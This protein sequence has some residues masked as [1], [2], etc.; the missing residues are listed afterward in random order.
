[1]ETFMKKLIGLI[2]PLLL[3]GIAIVGDAYAELD[4]S[5]PGPHYEVSLLPVTEYTLQNSSISPSIEE[6]NNIEEEEVDRVSSRLQLALARICVSEA[7]FQVRTND[8]LLIYHVLRNRSRSRQVTIGIMRAYSPQSFNL[9][10]RDNHRW[11]SHLRADGRQPRG[12]DET[13]TI[14]WSS[15]REGWM[16]VYR[17]AGMLLESNPGN[18][19]DMRV[20]HWG[21]P[22]YRRRMHIRNGWTPIVC[23][24]TR[25]QFW[26]LPDR[27]RVA[28]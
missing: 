12:W 6:N 14:P 21:A 26:S 2:I 28:E 25:N 10:R 17:Y 19:C 23:G 27:R 1:M 13:V 24:E 15:R 3:F 7:G 8:C 4:S 11:V 16:E 9:E 18:P 20:D 5:H 22:Y